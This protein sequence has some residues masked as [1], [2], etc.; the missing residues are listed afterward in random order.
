MALPMAYSMVKPMV[1]SMAMVWLPPQLVEEEWGTPESGTASELPRRELELAGMLAEATDEPLEGLW[2]PELVCPWAQE[3]DQ[4]SEEV[5]WGT[6]WLGMAS[7][8]P[9]LGSELAPV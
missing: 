5:V 4:A 1:Y 7:V 6:P 8:P 3:S 2:E 9:K